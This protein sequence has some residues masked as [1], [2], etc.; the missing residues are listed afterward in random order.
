MNLSK[1]VII[2]GEKSQKSDSQDLGKILI[3]AIRMQ[4]VS[5]RGKVSILNTSDLVN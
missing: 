3:N 2:S 1:K 4:A 5:Y